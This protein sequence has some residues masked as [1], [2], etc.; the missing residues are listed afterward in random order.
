[1]LRFET[2]GNE[3][4]NPRGVKNNFLNV[5]STFNELK[6]IAL[7]YIAQVWYQMVFIYSFDLLSICLPI[8]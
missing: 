1:M 5:F 2:K 6:P 4:L 7:G 3:S 8:L